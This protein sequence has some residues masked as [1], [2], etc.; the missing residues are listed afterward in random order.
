MLAGPD[1]PRR[2]ALPGLD[3]CVELGDRLVDSLRRVALLSLAGLLVGPF[4]AYRGACWVNRGLD[5]SPAVDHPTR[6]TRTWSTRRKNVTSYHMEVASWR[7]G[8]QAVAIDIAPSFA[9]QARTGLGIVVTTH[10]G[11]LGWEWIESFRLTK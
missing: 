6:I 2:V 3:L 7:E 4:G 8:E 1:R 11:K 9:N 5:A 10:A